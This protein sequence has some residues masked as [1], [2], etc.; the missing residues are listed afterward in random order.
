MSMYRSKGPLG[1]SLLPALGQEPL[2]TRAVPTCCV[3]GLA[4][5][6]WLHLRE[7]SAGTEQGLQN[8]REMLLN[9]AAPARSSQLLQGQLTSQP[10]KLQ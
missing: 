6:P 3:P 2:R 9:P 5:P 4:R 1:F 8:R 7:E 10:K